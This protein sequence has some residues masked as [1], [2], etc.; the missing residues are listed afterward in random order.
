MNNSLEYQHDLSN[1][2]GDI[3][4]I[5]Q[6]YQNLNAQNKQ[7]SLIQKGQA[8]ALETG[9]KLKS[10][11]EFAGAVETALGS[12]YAPKIVSDIIKPSYYAVK[13]KL[14]FG[15]DDPAEE[16]TA[17]EEATVETA[18]AAPLTANTLVAG[19]AE[20]ALPEPADDIA[21][22]TAG[23]VWTRGGPGP[24]PDE[25]RPWEFGVEDQDFNLEDFGQMNEAEDL[26]GIAAE[27]P[28]EGT[29][30]T[31]AAVETV[32]EGAAAVGADVGA[33]VGAGAAEAA[34][35]TTAAANWWNPL[36]IALGI[37]GL[38]VGGYEAG[39]ALADSHKAAQQQ[40]AIN[41][42]APP[43]AVNPGDISGSY[44]QPVLNQANPN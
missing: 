41:N 16:A 35:D 6:Y 12:A 18:D 36:G 32:G 24:N 28:I 42:M 34:I 10:A 3:Q 38:A 39:E 2:D 20:T 19:N 11:H 33:A 44:I 8:L 15:G 17:G 37:A 7:N 1:F 31:E 27:A 13:G 25:I 23:E 26:P 5:Q 43:A 21:A 29:T 4:E 22:D 14:G 9:E 40:Q 30:A